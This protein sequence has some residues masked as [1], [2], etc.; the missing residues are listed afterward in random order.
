MLLQINSLLSP[1]AMLD[2]FTFLKQSEGESVK[3]MALRIAYAQKFTINIDDLDCVYFLKNIQ[4]W[5]NG[6]NLV[7]K[8]PV[9]SQE[10]LEHVL[11]LLELIV[12]KQV[13]ALNLSGQGLTIF[14]RAIENLANLTR[15]SLA[16]N[17]IA[18]L[19]ESLCDLLKLE[20]LNLAFNKLTTI[21]H[22]IGRLGQLSMLNLMHN[23]LT[24][25]PKSIG[26]LTS[27]LGLDISENNLTCLPDE[28]IN[29][30]GLETLW[31]DSRVKICQ[32]LQDR[33][34]LDI[35]EK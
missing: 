17:Q 19:P 6:K 9:L 5:V 8:T 21:A 30:I 7:E 2:C 23:Q 16:Y 3:L 18:E 10:N 11:P 35:V 4:N 22:H 15:L 13:T 29:L 14:P 33:G 12:Q 32:A 27:L 26:N 20:S 24:E 31:V 1:E 34:S 25:L 28:M